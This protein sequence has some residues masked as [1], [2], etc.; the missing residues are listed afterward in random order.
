M[1]LFWKV[2]AV[3]WLAT[4]LVGGSGFLVSRALQQDWMLLQFHP[5]LRDFASELVNEYEQQGPDQA[6]AWLEQQLA[7]HRL[8]AR[9]FDASGDP[10]LTGTLWPSARQHLVEERQHKSR[11]NPYGRRFQLVWNSDLATY[12]L[13]LHVP[14]PE[15]FRWQRTPFAL[16]ANIILAM[17]LLAL[18]SLLLSRYLTSPLRRLGH[19]AQALGEG[20]YQPESLLPS[21]RR[22][23]EIGDLSRQFQHMASRLQ[24]LLDSQQQLMRDI[25]HELR[26]PLA[27][28]RIGLALASRQPLPSDDPLWQRLDRECS[29]LDELIGDILTLSRLDSHD[30]PSE[31]FDL[32]TLVRESVADASFSAEHQR[33]ELQGQTR[34]QLTGWPQQIASALD[35]LLRNA[36]RFTPE[37]GQI[38]I[39][40][41]RQESQAII[42][43]EDSGPGVPD[44]WL[45]QL[46]EPFVRLPGQAA[47]SGHGLGLAIARRAID[48]HQGQLRFDRSP[49]LGGLRATISLPLGHS[50][51]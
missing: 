50:R 32:D 1:R 38:N 40:L 36:L 15:L 24:T 49:Q 31:R 11:R 26:S 20:Q 7:E 18:L 14:T 39:L 5:Q 35:N 21:L 33:I 46:G 43:I 47:D 23:D 45:S 13:S 19:A 2:F 34:S 12:Q 8:R 48:R 25:S 42:R 17:A 9:L 27:R 3:L 6:Q 4:L 22:R 16:I 37:N 29:R 10:L 51:A 41:A 44:A 30:H 28:L